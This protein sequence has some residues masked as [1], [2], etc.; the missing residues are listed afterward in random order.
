MRTRLTALGAGLVLLAALAALGTPLFAAPTR[1]AGISP[2]GSAPPKQSG[3]R[4]ESAPP[5]VNGPT[6]LTGPA[7]PFHPLTDPTFGDNVRANTDPQSP[8]RAQQEPSISV[9]P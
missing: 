9:N 2:A 5:V 6:P 3:G 4:R 1:S 7:S 8:N